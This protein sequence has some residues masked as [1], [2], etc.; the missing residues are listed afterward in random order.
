[1]DARVRTRAPTSHAVRDPQRAGSS[2]TQRPHKR[3]HRP[4]VALG[5]T[6]PYR[7]RE[8]R[9]SSTRSPTP[10]RRSG[11][12]LELRR[13]LV[14]DDPRRP[15]SVLELA[16]EQGGLG[17]GTL[18]EGTTHTGH[19]RCGSRSRASSPRSQ[20]SPSRDGR[21]RVHKVTCAVDCGIPIN[22]DNIKAQ[23]EGGIGFG[24]AAALHS[25]ITLDQGV[26]VQSNFHDYP[27]LRMDEM[28][29]V[30]VH[31]VPSPENPTGVGEP[32]VPPSPPRWPTPTGP[33]P[34]SPS[35]SSRSRSPSADGPPIRS[36]PAFRGVPASIS[37]HRR[38]GVYPRP[39]TRLTQ[40]PGS[41]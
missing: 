24:L 14:K 23:M 13:E 41:P 19:R 31:I 17:S 16:A 37:V 38:G 20:R 5:G 33:S 28:P 36:S 32:G 26:P 8:P 39:P 9:A 15:R 12:P 7:V 25:E 3:H 4:V 34:E 30:D 35:G 1:M 6:H 2:S 27:A 40:P 18:P 22:P 10:S 21:V 29:A 11:P